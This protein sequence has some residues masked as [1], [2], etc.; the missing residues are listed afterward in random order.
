MKRGDFLSD[1]IYVTGLLAWVVLALTGLW[2][3][4]CGA[5]AE[6]VGRVEDTRPDAEVIPL[7]DQEQLL[8]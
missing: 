8:A 5:I 4:V 1:L 3:V 6:L 7:F 2:F